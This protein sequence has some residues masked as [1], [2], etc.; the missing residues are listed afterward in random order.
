MSRNELAFVVAFLIPAAAL[1]ERSP[2]ELKADEVCTFL[3]PDPAGFEALFTPAFI[4]KVTK[5]RLLSITSG[6]VAQTG[7]CTAARVPTPG[8][9]GEVFFTTE[10]G[11][12][13][14][15]QMSVEERAPHL[16]E[17]P[18][19]RPPVAQAASLDEVA[20]KLKAL[21][22]SVSVL[23][24]PL[25]DGKKP[26]LAIAEDK[27]LAIGSAFKLYLLAELGRQI[28]AGKRKAA[29]VVVLGDGPRSFSSAFLEKWP[30]D[31]PLTLHTVAT[32]M[33]SKSD[34]TATDL[35]LDTL[36]RE[37]VEA[38][39]PASGHK[40]PEGMRP[41]LSTVDAFRLKLLADDATRARWGKA[42]LAERRKILAALKGT[43][44]DA[45]DPGEKP[46]AIDSIEWFASAGDLC[47]VMGVLRA[48]KGWRDI[49]AVN[50]G[51]S[52]DAKRWPFIGFK[53]GSESGVINLT[54]LLEDAAG[55]ATCV[56][57]TWNDPAA[58]ID[59]SVFAGLVGALIAKLP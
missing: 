43:L 23:A 25:D 10:K 31:A 21:K 36:G 2:L 12:E 5:E 58:P 47:R 14:P 38:G 1:A 53:G 26:S 39:L 8:L 40:H 33:I 9:R 56:A 35:M 48:Q 41:F 34:N 18:M 22:G 7:R 11:F 30:R 59:E 16:I 24:L 54:F 19:L 55:K 27:P 20:G 6:T 29:D 52:I 45:K 57:A 46:L 49:L 3:R 32:M 50:P 4:S 17:G 44:A 15:A 28:A 51:L 37:A 13:I 42:N